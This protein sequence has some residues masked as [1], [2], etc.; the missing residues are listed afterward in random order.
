MIDLHTHSTASDGDLSPALLI[1]KAANMG[2]SAIALTDHDTIA[3]L[4]EAQKAA[5]AVKLAF[6]PGI[7]LETTLSAVQNEVSSGEATESAPVIPAISGEFHLLGLGLT[8]FSSE[9]MEVLAFLAGARERRNLKMIE[10]MRA[11]GINADYEEIRA[12]AR[13]V[14]GSSALIVGRPHFAAYLIRKRV[15]KNQEQAF[16]RY[17]GKGKLFYVSREGLEFEKAVR[18]IH[19]SG[20]I[21]VLAHPKTLHV[22]WGRLPAFLSWLKEKGLD[23]IEAWHPGATIR[24]C[25]RMEDLGRSLGLCITAGSDYHGQVRPERRL[26]YTAGDRKIGD[27]FLP[28]MLRM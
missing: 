25:K 1:E 3:G 15:V 21:A 23:G 7:E 5:L 8:H 20:G 4:E 12:F 16:K 2:F 24:F 10:K 9:F 13:G 11:A 27:E 26:G 18:L 22:S 19:E 6:I 28:E 14:A 17:L